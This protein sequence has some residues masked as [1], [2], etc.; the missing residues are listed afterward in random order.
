MAERSCRSTLSKRKNEVR[1]IQQRSATDPRLCSTRRPSTARLGSTAALAIDIHVVMRVVAVECAP[2]HWRKDRR[3]VGPAVVALSAHSLQTAISRRN[4][5]VMRHRSLC[6]GES[7]Q[8]SRRLKARRASSRTSSVVQE[9]YR[10][11][12]RV[13]TGRPAWSVLRYH[14]PRFSREGQNGRS[15]LRGCRPGRRCPACS[16]AAATG[17]DER[18]SK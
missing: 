3:R 4:Q 8:I 15:R 9:P 10:D 7:N 14:F 11:C 13:G 18:E 16:C 17:N 1:G 2:R 12:R 6:R 5:R